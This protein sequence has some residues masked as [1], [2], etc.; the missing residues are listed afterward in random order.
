MSTNRET[1]FDLSS[2]M[3]VQLVHGG[4]ANAVPLATIAMR[5]ERD[6]GCTAGMALSVCLWAS[7]CRREGSIL[8]GF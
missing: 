1:M 2:C 4:S 6:L 7:F 8:G 5:I 3:S